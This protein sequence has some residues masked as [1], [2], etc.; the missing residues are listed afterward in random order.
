M[1]TCTLRARCKFS[2][3]P[4]PRCRAMVSIA[5]PIRFP[6]GRSLPTYCKV[7]QQVV[8]SR[9]TFVLRKK[10]G[11]R[12][13]KFKRSG[14]SSSRVFYTQLYY[15][16]CIKPPRI[17]YANRAAIRHAPTSFALGRA[18]LHLRP[19]IGWYVLGRV[20]SAVHADFSS[21]RCITSRPYSHQSGSV[22]RRSF[23]PFSA[24]E[25]VPIV[26][27]KVA[28]TIPLPSATAEGD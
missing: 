18:G 20:D 12:T 2:E 14:P 6:R 7:H 23:S 16:I 17:S 9:K 24:P 8:L 25:P 28:R 21:Y 27:A 10:P 19:R 3:P 11:T 26:P 5:K 1:A 15:R 4:F 13:L 22:H